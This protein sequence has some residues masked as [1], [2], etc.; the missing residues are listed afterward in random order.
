METSKIHDATTGLKKFRY[1][2]IGRPNYYPH[3]DN[4]INEDEIGD[5]GSKLGG[6]EK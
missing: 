5:E 6:N 4:R 2:I 1:L 3:K